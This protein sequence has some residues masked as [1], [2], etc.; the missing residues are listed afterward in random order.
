MTGKA[1]PYAILV[2]VTSSG[3]DGKSML[4][5]KPAYSFGSNSDCEVQLRVTD[6][7]PEH[8]RIT[9]DSST[10]TTQLHCLAQVKPLKIGDK[11]VQVGVPVDLT[12]GTVFSIATKSFRFDLPPPTTGKTS[13][14]RKKRQKQ[15]CLF[16]CRMCGTTETTE[17]IHR[18]L[19]THLL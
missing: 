10:G 14:P 15:A 2:L 7:E 12:P 18:D 19:T 4:L 5:R 8:A 13:A 17:I 11:I 1:P 16:Q 9:H 6:V 3:L